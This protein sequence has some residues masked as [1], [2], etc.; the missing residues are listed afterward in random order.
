[1]INNTLDGLRR[2]HESSGSPQNEDIR[3]KGKEIEDY[4]KKCKKLS[5]TVQIRYKM[6]K[7][8]FPISA[9]KKVWDSQT[10]LIFSSARK[11]AKHQ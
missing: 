5:H 9:K 3:I 11:A 1:M 7:K 10:F 6:C 8:R 4:D 2:S